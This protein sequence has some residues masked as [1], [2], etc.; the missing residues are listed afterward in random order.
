MKVLMINP[1]YNSSKYKFI[2]LV[3]PPLGIAYIAAM[4]ERNG[5]T[6]RILDAPALE[7][8]H[9]AVK[10]EIQKYSPD[11]ISITAVTPTIDSALKT[12][13]ISKEVSPDSITVL[14]G[15]H[16][17]FTYQEVLKNSYVDVVVCGEGEQTMVELVDAI[18]KG[19]NLKEVNGIAIKNF[20]TPPRKIIDD[21]DSIP[22]PARHLLPMDEYKILNMKLT[23]GTIVSGRGC[24]YNCSFC[25]SSAMHGHKLRLRSAENVVDEMEHLVNDHDIEMIAFMDD[26]FTINKNRVYEIC[27]TIKDRG[28]DNYWGCTARVDTI[29]EELLK[30]MKDAGCITMFLGVE[31]SDQQVLNHLNKNTN[32]NRIKKTF[33]LT[34]KYGMRTIASVVLGMPGDT[35]RSIKSTIKFVKTLEP[36]Y[37]VFS[38]AT[39]YPGTEFYL[40]AASENLIKIN[41]WSKYTLLSPVLETVD[42]S[43]EEL[44]KLQRKAFTEFYLRPGYIARRTWTDGPIILKTI[45]SIVKGV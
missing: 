1:P 41:D 25:A 8:D 42:C 37:A 20:K 15:Y 21:L 17:T 43:L 45:A 4:L 39:P 29:S 28:L 2:G 36:S 22:F 33:E 7:Y 10:N 19:K 11:I 38:L 5:V 26:T 44:R 30:T 32:I 35:K 14:G 31:S 34:K 23:T 24:P 9:D 40:K 27:E 6:V 3:A 12:A 13:Q 18:E 16:P